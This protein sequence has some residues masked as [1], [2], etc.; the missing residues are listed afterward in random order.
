MREVVV[1]AEGQTE[2]QFIKQIVAPS[3]R[4]VCVF[5]KPL[6]L[7]TSQTA[8]GGAISYDRLQF[9]ARNTLRQHPDAVLTTFLDLY[10]LDTSFPAFTE[11]VK[12]KTNVYA[13]VA[14]LEEALHEAIVVHVGCRFERFI[15][16]IQPYEYE[17]LLFSDVAALSEVEPT[18]AKSLTQLTRVRTSFSTPEHINDN[19]ESKPSK[20]LEDLLDPKYRKTSH[21]PRAAERI[22][23]AVMER[24]CL[25]FKAWLDKLRGLATS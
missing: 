9:H 14:C 16:H 3:L 17:G 5:L 20:R 1:I 12:K 15:P 13:R 18:W 2:E 11:A 6:L 10:G 22:T 25:H 4:P 21:G 24:E 19:Y 8:K 7:K 23:L